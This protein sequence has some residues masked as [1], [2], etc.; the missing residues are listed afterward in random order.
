[1]KKYMYNLIV[2]GGGS[3]GL[4]AASTAAQL[5]AK[6]ALIEGHKMG[7]ECLNTGCVPSKS[8]LK[9][10]HLAHQV[11][12]AGHYGIHTS[13]QTYDMATIKSY[14]HTT[15]SKIAP[16]D[17]IQRFQ[18]MGVKV[19]TGFARFKDPH[20]LVV[21]GQEITGKKIIIATGAR[22]KIPDIKGLKTTP[23]LTHENI[24]NMDTLPE[25]MAILGNG[26][27]A[28]ELGQA[29]GNLGVKV[30]IL[31]RHDKLL[32]GVHPKVSHYLMDQLI[33][34]GIHFIKA[35]HVNQ[36]HYDEGFTLHYKQDKTL[37]QLQCQALLVATGK[38]PNTMSLNLKACGVDLKESGHIKCKN[39]MQT[40]QKH[41]YACGDVVGPHAFT[42]M[43]NYQ[44][45][46][47]VQN[48]LFPMRK[49]ADYTRVPWV[50][51]TQPEIAHV[52]PYFDDEAIDKMKL[53]VYESSL[54]DND[55]ALTDDLSPGF[56]RVYTRKGIVV[57]ASIVSSRAGSL[58]PTMILAI[59]NKN[60]LSVFLSLILPYP[61]QGEMYKALAVQSLKAN[62]RPWQMAL[63]KKIF[64]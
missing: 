40:R 55:R 64:F 32:K 9:I 47:A 20:C 60:K 46:L 12:T 19:Y 3:A 27:M 17:S 39:N 62:T 49:K 45:V 21:N 24:F 31:M 53:K 33:K 15:I 22:V 5:G 41:I 2:I 54:Q 50:I 56:I 30:T 4:S 29:Y 28:L 1:M 63:V 43:A 13:H 10:G 25:T 61:S 11:K 38:S 16:H 6:V 51:Y 37:G 7:G 35:C 57:S 34:E 58:L 48:A 18:A 44:A 59:K 8:L 14:I 52:G 26:P 36:V 42:H 23:Y